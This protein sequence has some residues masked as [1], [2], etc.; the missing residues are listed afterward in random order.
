MTI[1]MGI[2]M[3][4][5][6]KSQHSLKHFSTIYTV[7]SSGSDSA[8]Q[9]LDNLKL[10]SKTVNSGTL[11]KLCSNFSNTQEFID[12]IS[13]YL[14]AGSGGGCGFGYCGDRYDYNSDVTRIR[15]SRCRSLPRHWTNSFR[16]SKTRR[17]SC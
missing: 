16:N 1:L 3:L 15:R 2:K 8:L 7:K 6:R 11:H 10:P 14:C 17:Y 9:S 13:K 12:F 4:V 5:F